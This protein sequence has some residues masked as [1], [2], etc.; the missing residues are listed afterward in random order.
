MKLGNK[1]VFFFILILTVMFQSSCAKKTG[2]QLAEKTTTSMQDVNN[3]IEQTSAQ[4]DATQAS[5]DKVVNL[6]QS[7]SSLPDDVK[8]AFR[9]FSKN[10]DT[11]DENA[12]RLNKHI[13]RMNAQS[14]EY[15]TEWSKSGGVYTSPDI[16]QLSQERR[17]N[18][19]KSFSN[20]AAA[21]AGMR[22]S[23]NAYISDI[24]QIEAFLSNDLTANGIAAIIP[25]AQAAQRD[26]NSLKSLFQPV[27][28][29]IEQA[30][31]AMMPGGA[32]AGG[33]MEKTEGMPETGMESGTSNAENASP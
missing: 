26:S 31:L 24:K 27:Q 19:Q 13:D 10:V 6:G 25:I 32:A 23:L 16:Q 33:S 17:V 11:M 12:S 8:Q 20:I 9:D 3:D 2:V 28:T 5:L 1:H 30:R 15:F 4:I 22:G 18:L 7:P 14:N 29:A 21:S